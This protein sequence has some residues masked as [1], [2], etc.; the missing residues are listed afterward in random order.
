[1]TLVEI[2]G[3]MMILSNDAGRTM[4]FTALQGDD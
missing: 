4:V 1:M 3:E 2:S